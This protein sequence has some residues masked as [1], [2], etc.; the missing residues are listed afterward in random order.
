M[1]LTSIV[2]PN[3]RRCK[4]LVSKGLTKD[5]WCRRVLEKMQTLGVE[6]S[7]IVLGWKRDGLRLA[8]QRDQEHMMI[9]DCVRSKGL[10]T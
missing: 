10:V 7:Y 1:L 6:E 4:R 5:V 9:A 3:V 8:K 2:C